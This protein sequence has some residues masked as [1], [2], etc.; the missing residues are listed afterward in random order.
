LNIRV[1]VA[2]CDETD[3]PSWRHLGVTSK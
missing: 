3:K 2:D 1:E